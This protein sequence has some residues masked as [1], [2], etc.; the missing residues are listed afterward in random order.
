MP[1]YFSAVKS[2]ILPDGLWGGGSRRGKRGRRGNDGEME[3]L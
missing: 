1:S 3:S 2:L